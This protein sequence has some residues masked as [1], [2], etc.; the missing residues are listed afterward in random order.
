MFFSLVFLLPLNADLGLKMKQGKA[1]RGRRFLRRWG[2]DGN[3][4]D[5]SALGVGTKNYFCCLSTQS[6]RDHVHLW[7]D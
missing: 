3:G 2:D 6:H 1:K 7:L 4:I 5:D